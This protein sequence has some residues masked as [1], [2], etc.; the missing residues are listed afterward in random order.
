MDENGSRADPGLTTNRNA[1]AAVLDADDRR[2]D[3]ILE[4]SGQEGAMDL[5]VSSRALSLA[6]PVFD[7]MLSS[8]YKEGIQHTTGSERTRI[9]LPED[10]GDAL[11]AI[12]KVTHHRVGDG[13][14][15]FTAS[16]MLRLAYVSDKYDFTNTLRHWSSIWLRKSLE[17]SPKE[18]L[19]QLLGAA[20]M[21]DA[22]EEF[23]Q[24]SLDVVCEQTGLSPP[25][26]L[27]QGMGLPEST[28][29]ECLV[30]CLFSPTDSGQRIWKYEGW[31]LSLR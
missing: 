11:L 27:L 29:G 16:E 7:R 24:I 25:Y 4:V 30:Q 12:C 21:L 6:S 17:Q 3:I 9:P 18:D 10:D 1:Y 15:V 26:D 2:C 20:C 22:W 19:G 31:I 13:N 23:S 5:Y 28:K 8:R 14:K